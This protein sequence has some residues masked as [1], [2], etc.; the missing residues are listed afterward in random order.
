M[1]KAYSTFIDEDIISQRGISEG[2]GTM[3]VI[4]AGATGKECVSPDHAALKII[5]ERIQTE[6]VLETMKAIS[7]YVEK[8][9]DK[10]HLELV[11]RVYSVKSDS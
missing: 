4:R 5:S 2:R 7:D 3:D 10:S 6:P 9:S 8:I 11:N 1:Y